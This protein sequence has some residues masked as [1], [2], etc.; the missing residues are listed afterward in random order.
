MNF[1][2]ALQLS[3]RGE[4]N[5][6]AEKLLND[7]QQQPNFV[8]FCVEQVLST[9]SSPLG[10]FW[11]LQ[12]II[13]K[14]SRNEFS[15]QER[16]MLRR[17]FLEWLDASYS[18][19]PS[20]EMHTKNKIALLMASLMWRDYNT[21]WTSA[22]R[23][24]ATLAQKTPQLYEFFIRFI[25][26]IHE[27][28]LSEDSLCDKD[29]VRIFKAQ[30]QE[31]KDMEVI[32]EVWYK[33]LDNN[34]PGNYQISADTLQCMQ[35]CVSWM[36]FDLLTNKKLIDAVIKYFISSEENHCIF[37]A[38]F[39][40]FLIDRPNIPAEKRLETIE[41]LQ[42]IPL[43]LEAVRQDGALKMREHRVEVLNQV[44]VA[45]LQI[46]S[47]FQHTP[48]AGVVWGK[49]DK[50]LPTMW[51]CF[52]GHEEMEITDSVEPFVGELAK[53]LHHLR[54]YC[55][56]EALCRTIFGICVQKMSYPPWFT[57]TDLDIDEERHITFIELQRSLEQIILKLAKFQWDTVITV[58]QRAIHRIVNE[59]SSISSSNNNDNA[60]CSAL[61]PSCSWREVE[62]ALTVL[63]ILA[64]KH[65][66]RN[67]VRDGEMIIESFTAIVESDLAARS[68]DHWDVQVAILDLYT[69]FHLVFQMRSNKLEDGGND[70]ITE[71]DKRNRTNLCRV[72][73]HFVTAIHAGDRKLAVPACSNFYRFSKL[74]RAQVGSLAPSIA[75]GLADVLLRNLDQPH[76][77][78]QRTDLGSIYETLGMLSPVLKDPHSYMKAILD[79]AAQYLC[80]LNALPDAQ[81]EKDLEKLAD[82]AATCIH[83]IASFSK[84]LSDKIREHASAW[85]ASLMSILACA[86]RLE[87]RSEGIRDACVFLCR[88]MVSVFK[89]DFSPVLAEF[90]QPLYHPYVQPPTTPGGPLTLVAL[91]P[92]LWRE[93]SALS[94]LVLIEFKDARP[95]LEKQFAGPFRE[96]VRVLHDCEEREKEENASVEIRRENAELQLCLAKFI[97]QAAKNQQEYF[98]ILLCTPSENRTP[99][100]NFLLASLNASHLLC[101]QQALEAL[102]RVACL[103]IKDE[104]MLTKFQIQPFLSR[105]LE[106]MLRVDSS[107]AQTVKIAMEMA[108]FLRSVSDCRNVPEHVKEKILHLVSTTITN[109]FPS[110][111]STKLLEML[112]A[113]GT[114]KHVADVILIAVKEHAQGG[115]MN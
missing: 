46:F 28:A 111:H 39:L 64:K 52:G 34:N 49:L 33:A 96:A 114:S 51:E 36:D 11:C 55:D 23:D 41:N 58:L 47:A 66:L 76:K 9:T 102:T 99:I 88:R 74:N 24:V 61:N 98:C 17:T 20:L 40:Q 83:C 27:E 62:S 2:S 82:L 107:N 70:N 93:L 35:T 72:V 53:N 110:K 26:R 42:L 1:E 103:A 92:S 108:S 56:T 6:E 60:S 44:G 85:E 8:Q 113:C 12:R 50:L 81:W 78:L 37:A 95:F 15:D 63:N 87:G 105:M 54:A 57:H 90:L 104:K 65:N 77:V 4:S 75:E 101:F 79:A 19:H 18:S 31:S 89:D 13:D 91:H 3:F 29:A 48:E 68:R 22:I 14:V 32:C 45:L 69:R 43:V 73:D 115:Q 97:S 67:A 7:A 71:K 38:N 30:L 100:V 5:A 16:M 25:T 21:A 84:E 10:K 80:S 109:A 112:E 106:Q 86:K 94:T 59:T